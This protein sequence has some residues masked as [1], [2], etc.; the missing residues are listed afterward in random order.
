MRDVEHLALGVL[1]LLQGQRGLAAAGAADDDQRHRR[2]V[3]RLLRVV[4]R[5]RLVEQMHVRAFGMQ[6]A[7]GLRLAASLR[8]R[9]GRVAVRNV[10]LVDRRAAQEA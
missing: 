7:Q 6:V 8:D 1:Q 10:R 2:T 4:E 9:L 3:D 5:D